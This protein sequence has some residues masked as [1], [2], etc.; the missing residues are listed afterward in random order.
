MPEPMQIHP[1]DIV[2]VERLKI[3]NVYRTELNECQMSY[4]DLV[5]DEETRTEDE[6]GENFKTLSV[7]LKKTTISLEDEMEL[8]TENILN[9]YYE[10][11][12]SNIT[13]IERFDINQCTDNDDIR[14]KILSKI[15]KSSG[16]IAES[17][18]RGG[19]TFVMANYKMMCFI[20]GIGN[21]FRPFHQL[22]FD[23]II[24][25]DMSDNEIMVG[26]NQKDS[27]SVTFIYNNSNSIIDIKYAFFFI[28][29]IEK[30]YR[31][32]EVF[33]SGVFE[34]E[35]L[36]PED[37]DDVDQDQE[38]SLIDIDEENSVLNVRSSLGGTTLSP[39]H[40]H[41]FFVTNIV[42]KMS[43]LNVDKIIVNLG[44]A[45]TI[46]DSDKFIIN[47]NRDPNEHSLPFGKLSTID[48]V[49]DPMMKFTDNVVKFVK[50]SDVIHTM[51]VDDKD[52]LLL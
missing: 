9:K 14:K 22:T 30:Y 26:R 42:R 48:V 41:M 52:M 25:N 38:M 17:S 4:M 49:V 23:L 34:T 47:T 18:R 51:I 36:E 45:S 11:L 1:N 21:N 44:L 5:E 39:R 15:F 29:D 3:M 43:N 12:N 2:D 13:N 50:D 10:K 8:S 7:E 16:E 24:N 20:N 6:L 40:I 37:I 28:K 32:I 19:A 27:P 33:N 35:P 31:K 46:M